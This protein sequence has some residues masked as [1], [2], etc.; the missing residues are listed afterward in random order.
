MNAL[1]GVPSFLPPPPMPYHTGRKKPI[2]SP[3][4][5]INVLKLMRLDASDILPAQDA[6]TPVGTITPIALGILVTML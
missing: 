3:P 4:L 5:R 2:P 1:E 6:Y